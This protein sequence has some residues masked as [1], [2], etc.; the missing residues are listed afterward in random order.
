MDNLVTIMDKLKDLKIGLASE[1]PR[2][3]F[4]LQEAQLNF[5]SITYDWP[6]DYPPS[7]PL[8]RVAPYLAKRK[9]DYAMPHLGNSHLI[10]AAD[11][12]VIINGIILEKP[13]SP[14]DAA[15]MLRSLSN[16]THRVITG[17]CLKNAT[18]ED[19]WA[20][21][22]KVTFGPISPDEISF[23]IEHF[24]PFDKAGSYGIQEWIG[25]CKVKQIEGSYTNVM[26]LPMYETYLALQKFVN[27]NQ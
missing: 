8:G 20:V 11:S 12:I 18:Y 2:R 16:Q 19:L 27:E 3:K 6:E 1:S 5:E 7:L 26:G 13:A 15:E 23:Y 24:N 14:K 4:L 10:L 22:T 25:Y 9:A 21:E 17:V